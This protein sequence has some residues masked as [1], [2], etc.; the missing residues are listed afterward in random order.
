[1]EQGELIK[2]V[3]SAQTGN[4]EAHGKLYEAFRDMVYSIALRETKSPSLAEDIVQ[5]TFLENMQTIRNLREPAAFPSWLKTLAYHQCTRYYKKKESRHEIIL[6][7]AESSPLFDSI[8][9]ERSAYIPDTSVE[10]KDLRETLQSMLDS[11]PET[12][13]SALRMFYYDELPLKSIAQAQNV[14]LSTANTRLNRGRIAVKKAIDDYERK[15]GVRLHVFAFLPLF[16]WLL[17]NTSVKMPQEASA[18]IL[19]QIAA[20]TAM[21]PAKGSTASGNAHQSASIGCKT[22][23]PLSAKIAA[24]AAALAIT[25]GTPAAIHHIQMNL[26]APSEPSATVEVVPAESSEKASEAEGISDDEQLWNV[27]DFSAAWAYLDEIEGRV[28]VTVYAFDYDGT[29]SCIFGEFQSDFLSAYSGTYAF[30]GKTL[31]LSHYADGDPLVCD[32]AL[33]A[34]AL[35]I[36]QLSESGLTKYQHNGDTFDL[37]ADEFNTPDHVRELCASFLTNGGYELP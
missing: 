32:Y 25:I 17:A 10:Q 20:H 11:L 22:A 28:Y 19:Q 14:P 1:M 16:K 26:T 34:E 18:A 2:T 30:D 9:E 4:A 33:D 29:F 7:S 37:Y 12:Q 13:S 27:L 36:T 23:M 21:E 8:P 15:Q 24:G 3:L 35:K 5:E 6:D 31:S